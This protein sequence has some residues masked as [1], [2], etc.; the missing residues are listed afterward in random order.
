MGLLNLFRKKT[1][2]EIF[3]DE[4]KRVYKNAV[5]AIKQCERNELITGVLAKFAIASTYDTLKRDRNLLSTSKRWETEIYWKRTIDQNIW[6]TW[7]YK[8]R[9]RKYNRKN[10]CNEQNV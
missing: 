10:K 3:R 7:L 6:K 2:S 9:Y 5:T 4:I 1:Q 8:K